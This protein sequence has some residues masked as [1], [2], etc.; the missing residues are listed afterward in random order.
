MNK[1]IIVK[2]ADKVL[3]NGNILD[4]PIKKE[5]IVAKSIEIFADDDPCIIHK[6][7]VIKEFVDE[8]LQALKPFEHESE[9]EVNKLNLEFLEF[10]SDAVICL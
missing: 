7:Y 1:K 3:Y 9:V 2:L 10:P 4:I 8:F 5:L 6:S